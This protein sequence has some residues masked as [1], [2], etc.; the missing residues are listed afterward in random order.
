MIQSCCAKPG[1]TLQEP[2]V[3]DTAD[4]ATDATCCVCSTSVYHFGYEPMNM[5]C[6]CSERVC[7]LCVQVGKIIHC[8]IC[9]KYKRKPVP[10]EKWKKRYLRQ[11]TD[12]AVQEVCPGCGQKHPVAEIGGH[13]RLCTPY[14]DYMDNLHLENFQLYR[15]RANDYEHDIKDMNEHMGLQEQKIDEL[16]EFCDAY[17]LAV[18]VYEA[19]KRVYTFEQQKVLGALNKLGRP[20]QTLSKKLQDI[21]ATVEGLKTQLRESKENHRIFGQKRRRL[22]LDTDNVLHDL[23]NVSLS[24]TESDT[25]PEVQVLSTTTIADEQYEA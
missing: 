20:L 5:G 1:N 25:E 15:D 18:A 22:G 16:E 3:T 14:R 17:K 8:P 6:Q 21:Q 23:V 19:E 2:V 10:D 12:S 7:R 9:R 13:E 4:Q 11:D 24:V